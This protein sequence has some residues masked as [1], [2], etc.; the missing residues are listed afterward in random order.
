MSTEQGWGERRWRG[1]SPARLHGVQLPDSS[2]PTIDTTVT[3]PH[4]QEIPVTLQDTSVTPIE[5][6]FGSLL[7]SMHQSGADSNHS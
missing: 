5:H 3:D 2:L 4:G 1:R 7:D 6:Y